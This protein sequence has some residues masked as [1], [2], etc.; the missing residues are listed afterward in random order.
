MGPAR[1]LATETKREADGSLRPRSSI[2]VIRGRRLIKCCPEQLRPAT[3]REELLEHITQDEQQQ[4]PWTFSRLT[5]N[6]EGNEFEDITMEVPDQ[7]E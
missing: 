7:Q 4:A 6:L 2:W 3:Q 5:Q 1:I